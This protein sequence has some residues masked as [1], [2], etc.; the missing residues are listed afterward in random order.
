MINVVTIDLRIENKDCPPCVHGRCK[1][2][3]EVTAN[4]STHE[5]SRY[6]MTTGAV[7]ACHSGWMGDS[8]DVDLVAVYGAMTINDT[9]IGKRRAC[10]YII[11]IIYICV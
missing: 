9:D 8:C 11:Y 5:W 4:V 6:P 10:V 2:T 7:C 1:V 3:V